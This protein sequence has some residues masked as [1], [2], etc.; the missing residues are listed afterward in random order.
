[1]IVYW[2][3][4]LVAIIHILMCRFMVV[5]ICLIFSVLSTIEEYAGFANETLFWMVGGPQSLRKVER[6]VKVLINKLA[7]FFLCP[8]SSFCRCNSKFSCW[9]NFPKNRR[10]NDINS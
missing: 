1:M 3:L 8:A 7:I 2:N 4:N 10:N 5:L 6:Q 9:N